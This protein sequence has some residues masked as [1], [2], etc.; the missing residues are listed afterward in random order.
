MTNIFTKHTYL[1]A[2]LISIFINILLILFISTLIALPAPQIEENY[3]ELSLLDKIPPALT[4][5]EQATKKSS[6]EHSFWEKILP[7]DTPPVKTNTDGT[8]ATG[9]NNNTENNAANSTAPNTA[10]TNTQTGGNSNSIGNTGAAAPTSG[11]G[12]NNAT[13]PSGAASGN[14]VSGKPAEIIPPYA[15]SK[16]APEYIDEARENGWQGEALVKVS[17]SAAGTPDNVTIVNSSGYKALDRAA[18]A[19]VKQWRFSPAK[20]SQTGELLPSQVTIPISFNL[21]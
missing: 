11:N 3:I 16:V 13:A 8:N 2:F 19:A 21:N 6:K 12:N 20:N 15:I 10:A 7:N 14:T 1:K 4:P 5:E 18:I 17:I 9:N